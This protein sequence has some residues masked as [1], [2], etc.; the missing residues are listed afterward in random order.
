MKLTDA[1]SEIIRNAELGIVKI[2]FTNFSNWEFRYNGEQ[3]RAT[4]IDDD[5]IQ[6]VNDRKYGFTSNDK[7]IGDIRINS[8]ILPKKIELKNV[9]NVILKYKD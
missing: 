5:F 4:V 6:K 7:L 3:V 9:R 8:E 1:S 2:D